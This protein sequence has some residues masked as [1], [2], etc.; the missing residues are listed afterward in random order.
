MNYKLVI[1][2]YVIFTSSVIYWDINRHT[3]TVKVDEVNLSKC[4][5]APLKWEELEMAVCTMCGKKCL[6]NGV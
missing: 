1:A 3:K 2:L 5:K 4:C 6:T